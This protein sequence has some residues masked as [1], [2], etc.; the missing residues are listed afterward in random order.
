MT[1]AEIT[2]AK[3]RP[4]LAKIDLDK[5]LKAKAY[6]DELKQQQTRLQEVA[7]AYLAGGHRG[8]V[9]F[10][11]WDTAGKGGTIRRMASVLDPR[12]CKVWPIGPPSGKEADQHYLYRF[13]QRLPDP[14]CIAMFDRSWYGRVLVERVEGLA[15]EQ[16]WRRAYDEINEF[17]R[18]LVNDGYRIA[19][20][21]LHIT[22]EEQ[23]R[24][25]AARMADPLKRWK[26]TADDLHNRKLWADYAV[27]I[28]EMLERTSTTYAPWH[29]IPANDKKYARVEAIR[30]IVDSLSD[31]LDLVLPRLDPTVERAMH[32]LLRDK[33]D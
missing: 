18:L 26:L 10:E 33:S 2:L 1:A 7:L 30:T 29:A 12:G 8:L 13:W 28:D 16:E 6:D 4:R 19:K 22:P 5:S 31:G 27:A 9:A 20:L 21:F 15:S 17:E 25:F 11:G 23:L 32:A 3:Q 14:G 24:R